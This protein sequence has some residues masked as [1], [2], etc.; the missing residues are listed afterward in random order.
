MSLIGRKIFR[1]IA[2]NE[3]MTSDDVDNRYIFA[4]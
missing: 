4:R 1:H 2:M 3:A